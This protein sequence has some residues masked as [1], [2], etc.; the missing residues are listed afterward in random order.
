MFSNSMVVQG[1]TDFQSSAVTFINSTAQI[2]GSFVS[3]NSEIQVTNSLVS[4]GGN[5]ELTN[6][7]LNITG[8]TI[9]EVGGCTSINNSDLVIKDDGNWDTKKYEIIKQKNQTLDCINNG[10]KSIS[11]ETGTPLSDCQKLSTQQDASQTLTITFTI[12]DSCSPNPFSPGVIAGITIGILLFFII[13]AVVIYR[14][15]YLRN[16]VFPY[17]HTVRKVFTSSWAHRKED[18]KLSSMSSM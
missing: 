3:N 8:G 2:L 12:T 17:H 14:V 9:I 18:I 11:L 5:L 6:T 4:I 16:M 13:L 15:K 7:K 1:S 10:F